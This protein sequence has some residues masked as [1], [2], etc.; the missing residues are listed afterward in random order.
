MRL[1]PAIA[2]VT[3]T[4]VLLILSTATVGHSAVQEP[5]SALEQTQS[6]SASAEQRFQLLYDS[7]RDLSKDSAN[8]V[9]KT[10]ASLLLVIG[11]L[12]VSEGS[13]EFLRQNLTAWRTAL[14]VIPVMAVANTVWL[15]DRFR[16]SENKVDLL[17]GLDY[18]AEGYYAG[19]RI[20]P[21]VMA[22]DTIL[23]LALFA[24]I[25]G[26]IYSQRGARS[27]SK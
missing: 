26:L 15:I 6:D 27:G 17:D 19:D 5:V 22:T 11:W 23:H 13:R 18:L 8:D 2:A 9:L 4:T 16:I 24:A 10:I 21:V 7:L 1:R 12:M 3:G 14:V 25:F 20:T